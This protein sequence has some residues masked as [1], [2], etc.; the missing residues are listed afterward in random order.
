[1][2]PA[3]SHDLMQFPQRL[4]RVLTQLPVA[5]QLGLGRGLGPADVAIIVLNWNGREVTL[6]CLESLRQADLGGATVWVV[7]NGSRDDS[8]EAIRARYPEVR[9]LQ[10][11]QNQGYAGGNNAGIRAALDAGARAV[12]LLNNDTVVAPDFL[13]PLLAVL[14]REA[15]PA[16]VSSAIMRLDS[17]EVLQQAWCD[18]H[19][20]F[21][22]C[23]RVGVNALPGE[24]YDR[25]RRVDAAIGCSLLIAAEALARVGLLDESYFAYHEEIDWCVRA[26]KA[27]YHLYYQPFSRVYHHYSKSTDVARPARTHRTRHKEELPN[28]IPL[29][30]NPVRTY[31]GAR[32][33]VRFIRRHAGALRTVKFAAST[34]YNIPLELLAIVLDREEELH[35][36]LLS[37]RGALGRYCLEATGCGP[38]ERPTATQVIRAT[39]YAPVALLWDLPREIRRASAQGLTAQVDACVRGYW[40]GVLDR[41]LPLEQ[42]GLR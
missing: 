19:F 36:G 5:V 1:M 34:L 35:L 27:G 23:R 17:P 30:W 38:D 24:G 40:D 26:R 4:R 16:A 14:N 25:V 7:D 28:P 42:L 31:L 6:A 21:G 13:P 22:L 20:G 3:S 11:A 9:I 2:R 32:N 29:Q 10:L 41:P 15:R 8:V 33:S 12:L 39:C 18:V 37:Y